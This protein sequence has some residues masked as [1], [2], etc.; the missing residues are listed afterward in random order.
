MSQKSRILEH[1]K[2]GNSVTTASAVELFKIYR[3]SER[4]RELEKDDYR[5]WRQN[6]TT[7]GGAR[8]VRYRLVTHQE[9]VS[10]TEPRNAN[11]SA[12][13]DLFPDRINRQHSD[14]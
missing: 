1:L 10:M 9:F 13:F 5:M 4:I 7:P 3:L 12:K 8:I 2:K 11:R 6:E 14:Y